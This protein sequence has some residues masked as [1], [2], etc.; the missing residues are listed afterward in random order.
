MQKLVLAGAG[1]HVVLM[2]AKLCRM[3][4]TKGKDKMHRTAMECTS[5]PDVTM[6]RTVFILVLHSSFLLLLREK[7]QYILSVMVP[8]G[9]VGVAPLVALAQPRVSLG[10][11]TTG[12]CYSA[13][14]RQ[15]VM[16]SLIV[17]GDCRWSH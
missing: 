10:L 1:E 7:R 17:C 2:D 6:V 14:R 16:Y 9:L 15:A 5:S 4:G 12:V 11:Q 8:S 3:A 13:L